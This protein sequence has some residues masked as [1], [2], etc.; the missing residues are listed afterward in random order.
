MQIQPSL[1]AELLK[2]T[3]DNDTGKLKIKKKLKLK[4]F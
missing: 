2:L 4:L 1:K 3:W